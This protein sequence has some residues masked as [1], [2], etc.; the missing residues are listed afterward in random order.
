MTSPKV[1]ETNDLS[2]PVTL[3]SVPTTTESKFMINDKVIALGMLRINSFKT[4]REDKFVPINKVRASVRTNPITVSQPHVITKKHVNSDSNGLFSTGLDNTAKTRR[5]Q[6][7]SNTKNDK[8]S[9]SLRDSYIKNKEVE[10]E[11]HHRNL[12]LSK[13]KK[14]MSL[15]EI[16]VKSC[17]SNDKSEVILLCKQKAN[18]S[19]IANQKKIKP[20]VKKPKNVGSIERL[21]SPKPRKPKAFLRLSKFFLGTVRFGND[22]VAAILAYGDLQWGNILITGVYF[23]E[24]LRH[25]LFS[26]GQFCDSNLELQILKSKQKTNH[27]PSCLQK[28]YEEKARIK[29]TWYN[30]DSLLSPK[31]DHED[32]GKLGAK[33]DIGFFIGY[34]ATSYAYK[35]KA[36]A[37]A[38]YTQNHSIIHRHF[39]K[40]PY[41]FINVR[42]P[43]ISFLH[44]FEALCYPKNDHEDIGKLGAKAMALEQHSSKPRLQSMTSGQISS[45]LDLTYALSTITTQQLTERDW[46]YYSKPYGDM[47]IYALTVSTMELRNVKEAMT[48]PAWIDSMQE[49]LLQF[50]RLD[51][52]EEN[53]VI[54]N[55][56][57]LVVRGCHQEEGIDFEEPFA[58]VARMEAIRI[59]LAYAAHKSFT[60]FQ[61]DMKTAFL[62]GT[63]KEDMY[64]CQPE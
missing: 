28:P 52:D 42:K 31:N 3:N 64:V 14:H 6:P 48:D 20:K 49:E 55:K 47:C 17:Y 10:I 19:N 25:N 62:H 36:I 18:G 27:Y 13:N 16:I 40:T 26:V 57:C 2:N 51:H 15:N 58:P 60:V 41:E 29:K 54:R 61:M 38:C 24:G 22:H 34:S 30:Q 50:K 32:I 63:L 5:P 37:T 44:V 59:F 45:R 12:L 46:I 56:T 33:G 4:S 53:T 11:E 21:A 7:R 35:A 1:V 9:A 43:D 23:I 8:S 39:D